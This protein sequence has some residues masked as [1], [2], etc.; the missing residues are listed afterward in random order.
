MS[1]CTYCNST[2]RMGPYFPGGLSTVC[3]HCS[4]AMTHLDPKALEAAVMALIPTNGDVP[5]IAYAHLKARGE[6][7]VY[8]DDAT[9]TV[10]AYLAALPQAEPVGWHWWAKDAN[11]TWPVWTLGPERPK[12]APSTAIPLFASPTSAVSRDVTEEMV[13]CAMDRA[14]W[15]VKATPSEYEGGTLIDPGMSQEEADHIN[16][17]LR[18]EMR[19]ILE[20]A[21]SESHHG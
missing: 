2:G 20:A 16:D 11:S 5:A 3:A 19:D 18:I 9:K 7:L 8:M 21:L 6:H 17:Q 12:S 14:A 4:P 10:S 15:T 1:D 13:E